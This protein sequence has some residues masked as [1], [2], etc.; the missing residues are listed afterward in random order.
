MDHH[1]NET[2]REWAEDMMPD[3]ACVVTAL[4]PAND[5]LPERPRTDRKPGVGAKKHFSCAFVYGPGAGIVMNT[6]S[7][8]EKRV[9]LVLL[10][11]PDVVQLE[12]QVRFSWFAPDGSEKRH[13]FDFRATMADGD[14]VAIMV[15]Y[16]KKLADQAFRAEIAEIA[17][18]VTPEFSDRVTLMTEKHLD[19]IDVFNAT[20]FNSVRQPDEAADTVMRA[21]IKG[22]NG[23]AKVG[24]LIAHTGL[25]GRGFRSIARLIGL[26]EL[27]L[28]DR[29]R[30]DYDS[31]VM[32]GAA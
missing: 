4:A 27:Q 9:A 16:D 24:D 12:N 25:K 17:A 19:P 1:Q 30:V 21:A 8:T 2:N 23:A 7:L 20:L 28:Q 3:S 18:Q 11:R 10:A 32:R 5:G 29:V 26:R 6:D 15:K 13:Y 31:L 14:R 22:L